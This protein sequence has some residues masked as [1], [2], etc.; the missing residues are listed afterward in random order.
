M[1]QV[2]LLKPDTLGRVAAK[3]IA[4]FPSYL[5]YDLGGIPGPSLK[6]A[7]TLSKPQRQN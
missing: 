3:N 1:L 5:Y 7:A 2:T 6:M 4:F